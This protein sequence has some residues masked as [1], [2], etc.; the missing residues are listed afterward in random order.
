MPRP[1]PPTSTL[2]D[3]FPQS[4]VGALTPTLPVPRSG[5]VCNGRCKTMPHHLY[6]GQLMPWERHRCVCSPPRALRSLSERFDH[7]AG[8]QFF[9]TVKRRSKMVGC[10]ATG[11]VASG[12]SATALR[13]TSGRCVCLP[14]CAR[15]VAVKSTFEPPRPATMA[16]K[17][18]LSVARAHIA[19]EPCGWRENARSVARHVCSMS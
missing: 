15:V 19:S 8:A 5:R 10:G 3:P 12:L 4:L 9:T 18:F 1:L 17:H 11:P 13:A 7:A 14:L 2:P 6:E 16:V